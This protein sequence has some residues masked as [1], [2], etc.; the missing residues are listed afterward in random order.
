MFDDALG[1]FQAMPERNVVSWNAM[2]GG[3]SQTGHNEEAV[4]LFVEMLRE[5]FVPSQSTFPC[6]MSAAAN[7]A[8]LGM[9]RSFHACAIK[10]FLGPL[11]HVCCQFSGQFLRKMWKY[12]R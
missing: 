5:G 3:H 8:A 9:G 6:A 1:L 11:W 2:I 10:F 4:N 12:G 7:I